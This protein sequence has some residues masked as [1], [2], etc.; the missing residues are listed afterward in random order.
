[1]ITTTALKVGFQVIETRMGYY[2]N[3]EDGIA[4]ELCKPT[5]GVCWVDTQG[6][7]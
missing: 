1:M 6:L 4:V 2:E 7:F 5:P 3:G